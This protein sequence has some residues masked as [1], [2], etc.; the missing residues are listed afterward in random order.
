MQTRDKVFYDIVSK[1][2]AGMG[3]V[4]KNGVSA[5]SQYMDFFFAEKYNV[6][7][8][9]G[10][11]GFS[12]NPSLPLRP[13]WEQIEAG[14]RPYTMASYVD[15]DSDGPTKSTDGLS[16]ATGEIPTFKHEFSLNRKTLREQMM[17]T[18][19]IGHATPEIV[20]TVMNLFFTSLDDL[21]GGNY[22]TIAYQRH[23]L[24]SNQLKLM[25][26][27]TN[28][29]LGYAKNL[30]FEIDA[31]KQVHNDVKFKLFAK[32]N[33][34]GAVTEQTGIKNNVPFKAIKALVRDIQNKDHAGSVHI[35]VAKS[36]WEDI[37]NLPYVQEM[38]IRES[39]PLVSDASTIA[40][41]IASG[42]DEE[43]VTEFLRKKMG[44]SRIEQVD[45]LGASEY[46][47]KTTGAMDYHYH[48]G[49]KEGV[50]VIVPDGEIGDIQ[51]GKPFVMDTPGARTGLYD[52]GR[53]LIRNVFN[54]ENMV[55]TVKSEVTGFCVPNKT[56]WMHWI[57]V[58]TI[59]EPE[60]GVN[61][62]GAG[63][64]PQKRTKQD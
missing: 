49:F 35:E 8:F 18:E 59:T 19:A 3:F 24:V 40:S 43:P 15:I 11:L 57:N 38:Y 7:S 34:T 52:G 47:N 42:A 25:L 17:L 44:V 21:I 63:V 31:T 20:D 12:V 10:T 9:A 61:V 36:T 2:L 1:G 29:P 54:D 22:N 48:Q 6:D 41:L 60:D 39:Y 50:L 45:F 26:N 55:Q 46:F 13:M 30:G 37:C 23:Q 32:N 28:N 51:F 4:D 33:G 14:R 53:T 16:L 62:N 64:V 56:R 27:G 5:M 58:A